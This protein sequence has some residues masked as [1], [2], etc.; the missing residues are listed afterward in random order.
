MLHQSLY[1]TDTTCERVTKQN[2]HQ[3]K[4]LGS[5]WIFD[6][7]KGVVSSLLCTEDDN[8]CYRNVC[9]MSVTSF[10]LAVVFIKKNEKQKDERNLTITFTNYTPDNY[11]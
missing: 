1:E 11:I 8:S 9:K 5:T 2:L 6:E 4:V 7:T 10:A 3:I